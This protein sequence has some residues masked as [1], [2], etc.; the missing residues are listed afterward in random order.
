M[1]V[2][3]VGCQCEVCSSPDPRCQRT[4]TSALL[5]HSAT[6]LIDC[7]PDFRLQAL[8]AKLSFLDAVL[9]TH[10]HQD[11]C[12]GLDD[13][14]GLE[15]GRTRPI[16][17]FCH[18]DTAATLTQRFGYLMHANQFR[19]PVLEPVAV[20]GSMGDAELAGQSFRWVYYQQQD[21][22]VLGYRFGKLAYLT[23]IHQ[24][25]KAI[26]GFLKGVETLVVSAVQVSPHPYFFNVQQAI[27]FAQQAGVRDTVLTHMSHDI[28]PMIIQSLLP[29]NVTLA[30]DGLELSI[31]DSS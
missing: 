29:S 14:R 8:R 30:Y 11:H 5:K 22:A 4:R 26:L 28:N 13:L 10:A 1:G 20:S 25:S 17:M 9:I 6:I 31:A 7:S 16:P 3:I 2:P 21:T 15:T 18:E 12:G 19:M 27:E 23:D 24:C